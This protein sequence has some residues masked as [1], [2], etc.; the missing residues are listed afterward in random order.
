VVFAWDD[1]DFNSRSARATQHRRLAA[2]TSGR[3]GTFRMCGIPVEAGHSGAGADRVA[4]S[5]RR[6]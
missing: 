6:R 5:D 3:D 2:V 4:R 1:L